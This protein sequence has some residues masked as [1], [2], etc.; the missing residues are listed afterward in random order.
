MPEPRELLPG[1]PFYVE[2]RTDTPVVLTV[3]LTVTSPDRPPVWMVRSSWGARWTLRPRDG[4]ADGLW[5]VG[6]PLPADPDAVQ[7]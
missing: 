7:P 6:T 5:F 1:T 2:G 3:E 4:S